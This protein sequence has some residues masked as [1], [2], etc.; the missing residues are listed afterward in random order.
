MSVVQTNAAQT[1]YTCGILSERPRLMTDTIDRKTWTLSTPRFGSALTT[2]E[3]PSS[4][5]PQ[6]FENKHLTLRSSKT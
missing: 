3:M 5:K 2:L 1:A 4:L 6:T